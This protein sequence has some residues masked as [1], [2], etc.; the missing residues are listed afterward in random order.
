[1][2]VRIF[3]TLPLGLDRLARLTADHARR[4]YPGAKVTVVRRSYGLEVRVASR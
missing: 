1:M 4:A 3:A 2:T